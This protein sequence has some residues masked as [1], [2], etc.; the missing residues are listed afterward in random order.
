MI[1]AKPKKKG[2]PKQQLSPLAARK[3][4]RRDYL[5]AMTPRRRRM[6]AESQRKNCP[7]GYDY[8]HNKKACVKSS[9]NRGGTQSSSKKDGTK[10]EYKQNRK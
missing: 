1:M 6:K 10:A 7:D 9:I 3:K 8:D 4:A 5:Y 2:G